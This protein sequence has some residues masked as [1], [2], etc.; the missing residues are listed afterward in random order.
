M[1]LF[2][3]DHCHQTLYFENNRCVSCGEA[4]AYDPQNARLVLLSEPARLCRN[5]R[6]LGVVL[7]KRAPVSLPEVLGLYTVERRHP[8]GGRPG[9]EERVGGSIRIGHREVMPQAGAA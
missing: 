7:A 5:G 2:S 6:D 8:A 9:L 3:C 4:V 1:K